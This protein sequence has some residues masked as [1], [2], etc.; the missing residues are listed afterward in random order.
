MGLEACST[1]PGSRLSTPNT[2]TCTHLHTQSHTRTLTNPSAYT[3]SQ[4]YAQ[5]RIPSIPQSGFK[6][7]SLEQARLYLTHRAGED[8]TQ[9]VGN[10]AVLVH[11]LVAVDHEPTPRRRD[12][13]SGRGLEPWP[14]SHS[15]SLR[16]CLSVCF[17]VLRTA[18]RAYTPS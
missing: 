16:V 18:F 11:V 10:P 15:P 3:Q 4:L 5:V 1:T 8:E 17:V 12:S 14:H 6:T 2:G 13:S 7:H 9:R